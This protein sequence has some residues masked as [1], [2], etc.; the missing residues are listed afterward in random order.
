MTEK[1]AFVFDTNFIIQNQRLDEVCDN[2][3]E[4]Y[5]VYVSQVSI[6]ER[7][8]QQ[9]RTLKAQFDEIEQCRQKYTRFVTISFKKPYEEIASRYHNEIQKNYEHYFGQNI[10]P[11]VKDGEMLTKIFDRANQKLP[12]FSATKEASDKGFK[13]CLL[14]LSILNYFRDNGE[15]KVIFLT[16][17]KSAFRNHTEFLQNEFHKITGKTIEIH[18]N[19]Y[20]RELLSQPEIIEPVAEKVP[21]ELPDLDVIRENIEEAVCGL[22]GVEWEDYYGNLQ[23]SRTFTS[24]IPFDKD[25]VNVIFTGLI[26]VLNEHLFEKVIPASI[27]LNYDG[28]ISDCETGIPIKNLEQVLDLY[29]AV[30]EKY[31]LHNEQFFE[32]VANILNRNYKAPSVSVSTSFEELPF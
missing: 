4:N 30:L 6:E 29:H 16:D 22:L 15:N 9:C 8:A 5:T 26:D 31:P 32:A 12:P 27:V 25:Y 19:A 11:F 3:R 2:L 24:S 23:W 7:I 10:I 28:R 1:T 17:D 14:W 13:D 18:P 21:E 20:Y